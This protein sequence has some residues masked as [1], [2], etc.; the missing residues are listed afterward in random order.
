[1]YEIDFFLNTTSDIHNHSFWSWSFLERSGSISNVQDRSKRIVVNV[2]SSNI[3]LNSRFKVIAYSM[4]WLCRTCFLCLRCSRETWAEA[5]DRWLQRRLQRDTQILSIG[6]WSSW[7]FEIEWKK[8]KENH[9]RPL[10]NTIK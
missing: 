9:S 1:M 10:M 4:I 5:L 7:A 3:I 6:K 8:N 2:R